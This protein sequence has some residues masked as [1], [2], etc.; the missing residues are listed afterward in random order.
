MKKTTEADIRAIGQ[1]LE[2]IKVLIKKVQENEERL[3]DDTFLE[4]EGLLEYD[5]DLSLI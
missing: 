2:K 1:E 3:N 5:Y 4:K